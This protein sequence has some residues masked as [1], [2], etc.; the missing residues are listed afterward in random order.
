MTKEALETVSSHIEPLEL[1]KRKRE[2]L[3]VLLLG[4]IFF[5]LTWVEIKLFT[6]S[7]T[8]PF[9][10]SIFFFGLV[11]FNIVLLLLLGF[12]VFRNVVK[13]FVEGQGPIIGRSLK[14]KLVAAFSFFTLVP[15]VLMFVVSVLYINSSFDKWFSE[16][17]A[18][19]LKNSLEVT[20][21]YNISAKKKNYHF[22]HEIAKTVSAQ[23]SLVELES[24]L[25]SLRKQFHLDSVEFYRKSAGTNHRLLARDDSMPQV[26]IGPARFLKAGLDRK[27]EASTIQQFNRGNLIRVIVP[28]R[29]RHER[30][31]VVVSTYVPL[32]LLSKMDDIASAYADF[33]DLNPLHY[34]LKS[35]YL[36]ILV[37]VT[38]V[39]LLCATWFGFYLARQLSIPLE[40]LGHATQQVSKGDYRPVSIFSGSHEI[41]WLVSNFN[42]MTKNLAFSESQVNQAN[43]DLHRTLDRLDEHTRYI[44]IVLS[45]VSTGVVALNIEGRITNIN[46]HAA[47]LLEI[48][49]LRYVGKKISEVLDKNQ[50]LMYNNLVESLTQTKTETIRKDLRVPV[51]GRPLP[52]QLSLSL[53]KDEKGNEL[54]RVLVFDDLTVV[55]NAQRAA[56]WTEVA[57]RIAH[58]IKNPLTPIKLAAQRL[59]RKFGGMISDEA[60]SSC[61]R[62]IIQSVDQMKNLVNEFN[63]FARLPE[64]RPSPGNLGEVI[65]SAVTLYRAAHG[66]CDFITQIDKRLP[67]FEFDSDQINRVMINLLDNAIAAVRSVSDPRIFVAVVYDESLRMVRV[68]VADNG[69]GVTEDVLSYMFEPYYSTK[70]SGSGLGLNIVKRIVEDHDGFIRALTNRPAG[71]QI[72]FELPLRSIRS[73]QARIE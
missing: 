1:N 34:P 18:G 72:V 13:V 21:A 40:L 58:E 23:P 71:L 15:T 35:I 54:G 63:S 39:I 55:L 27:A 20:N 51:N 22:A 37:L 50:R 62:T 47:Q 11:N 8:L 9:V 61:V 66:E 69:I 65:E 30:A 56:A 7:R 38:F 14:A 36:I 70:E 32:S 64:I 5:V 25:Q 2:I 52:L 60:F 26:P 17:M 48:N 29:W 49:P 53:L 42:K 73:I 31:A 41:N 24:Q 19:V 43:V 33:R 4:I 28:L 16:K 68:A 46:R 59:Q 67:V 6:I 10:D 3:T 44:E 12:L 45:N 57:R